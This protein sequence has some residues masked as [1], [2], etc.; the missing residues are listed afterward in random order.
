MNAMQ[1]FLRYASALAIFCLAAPLIGG[2]ILK[3]GFDM[4]HIPDV[5][6]G[7]CAKVFY[8]ASFTAYLLLIPYNYYLQAKLLPPIIGQ[9]IIIIGTQLAYI[10]LLLRKYTRDA[11]LVEAGAVLLTNLISFGLIFLF[12]M[13]GAR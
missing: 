7:Y 13:E 1:D 4:V 10:P 3:K 9:A 5:T 8:A 2:F 6:L 12:V 11:L